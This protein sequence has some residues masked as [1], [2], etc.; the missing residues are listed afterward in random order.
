MYWLR[1]DMVTMNFNKSK[2]KI[3]DAIMIPLSITPVLTTVMI[4]YYVIASLL[5]AATVGITTNFV[6]TSLGILQG[7]QAFQNILIPFILLLSVSAY[8]IISRALLHFIQV[9]FKMNLQASLRESFLLKRANL[10]FDHIENTTD[11]DLINR[12]AEKPE[13]KINDA[14]TNLLGLGNM[15]LAIIG[16]IAIVMSQVF[17]AAIIMIIAAVPIVVVALDSGKK[18]YTAQQEVTLKKRKFQYFFQVLTDR[19]HVL[20]RS[21]FGYSPKLQEKFLCNF[22]EALSTELKVRKKMVIRSQLNGMSGIFVS[23]VVMLALIQPVVSGTISVGMFISLIGATTSI[24]EMLNWDLSWYLQSFSKDIAYFKE[25]T[26]FVS[27]SEHPGGTDLP[28]S[29]INISQIEFKNVSFK[30]PGADTNTLNNVS[31]VMDSGKN[32]SFVGS[33]GA[34]KTTITKLLTG[35]YTGYTGEILLNGMELRSYPLACIKA[36]FSEVFQDFSKY[37]I[38]FGENIL[39][40]NPHSLYANEQIVDT[41]NQLNSVIDTVDLTDVIVQLPHGV[42]SK[43]GKLYEDGV[44]LSGGQWQR[45][46]MARSIFSPSKIKILD[47]PTAALDPIAES[48]IYEKF[49]E[50]SAGYT[51][52]FISHRLA[53]TQLADVIFVMDQ[54]KIVEQG[55]HK[56]LMQKKG[57]YFNMYESQRSWYL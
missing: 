42:D 50:I 16:I 4:L 26:Q 15:V 46:A 43:L 48:R 30:Y 29:P 45:I 52:I 9:R 32:Y 12:V 25:L 33:N 54:G 34:G 7:Y 31:F 51:S 17:W 35:L 19:N 21:M 14:F 36:T 55:S 10:T 44:D 23:L 3:T 37:Q 11:W 6:D 5:P 22:K 40:G 2:Y 18:I 39:L 56:G 47:E 24:V 20:E 27:L 8:Q 1:R 13:D 38:S 53:S 57:I 49:K 41:Q 28:S